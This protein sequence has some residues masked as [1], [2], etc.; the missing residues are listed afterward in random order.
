[1]AY[2]VD[3]C[4]FFCGGKWI[5]GVM[6]F[7][8]DVDVIKVVMRGPAAPSCTWLVV[9]QINFIVIAVVPGSMNIDV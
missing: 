5:I 3:Y 2:F 4:V 6:V 8:G 7:P 1:M 9:K